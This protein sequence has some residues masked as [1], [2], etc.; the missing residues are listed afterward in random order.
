MN[1][2]IFEDRMTPIQVAEALSVTTGTLASWRCTG[3]YPLP[4]I[5]VGR[6]VHYRGKDVK[7]FLK[8]R[9]VIYNNK[10]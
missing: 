6:S 8:K 7:D 10:K 4:F 2:S 3:R 1:L 5:K 9:T